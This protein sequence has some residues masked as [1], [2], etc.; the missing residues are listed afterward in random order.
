MVE[1]CAGSGKTWLLVSRILRLLLAGAAPS[2]ILAITFTRKAAQEMAGAPAA[3]GC[4]CW[5]W[6]RKTKCATF[7]RERAVPEHEIEALLPRARSLLEVLLTAQPGI[8]INTF[9]GWFLQLLQRAPLE[10]GAGGDWGLLDQTSA[11][12]EEAW[13][14]FAEDL[15]ARARWK[16]Q[17]PA[18]WMT[19]S[20]STACTTPA[21]AAGFRR[22]ARR[23]VGL[24]RR[25][26]RSARLSPLEALAPRT[27]GG[28]G[29]GRAG[30]K[31][32][33]TP[34]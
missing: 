14:S 29:A 30:A 5:R 18:P 26:G 3:T 9:H 12:L 34:Y 19:C 4:A 21:P 31:C 27:G 20:P 15:A 33:R 22:Q 7:L 32:S 1:A 10:G 23:V 6:R 24:H 17:L 13:Q 28:A 8:T 25:A 2:E 11:L 16:T